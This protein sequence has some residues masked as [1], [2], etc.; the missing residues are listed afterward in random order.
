MCV[1]LNLMDCGSDLVNHEFFH[2]SLAMNPLLLK[3]KR[4]RNNLSRQVLIFLRT[5]FQGGC[6]RTLELG[7]LGY[8][9]VSPTS[10]L[11]ICC[12]VGGCR[13]PNFTATGDVSSADPGPPTLL[14]LLLPRRPSEES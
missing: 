8:P 14:H 7:G 11:T 13:G 10:L 12:D 5:C 3:K 2:I 6:P 1:F 4:S 9:L